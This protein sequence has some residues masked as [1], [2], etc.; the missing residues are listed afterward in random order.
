LSRKSRRL[1]AN[2][3]KCGGARGATND[4]TTW[5]LRMEC[6]VSKAT[7]THTHTDKYVIFIAIPRQQWFANASPCYVI[8]TLSVLLCCGSL[9]SVLEALQGWPA[10][11]DEDKHDTV[12]VHLSDRPAQTLS[13]VRW[14][15]PSPSACRPANNSNCAALY[16]DRS[17]TK[18]A[19]RRLQVA[20]T[21]DNTLLVSVPNALP[22]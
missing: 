8:H 6:W 5:R 16:F 2:V 19:L 9:D 7:C 15:T 10:R 1:W 4:V 21:V 12:V 17:S 20:Q 14:G 11:D 13:D 22:C 3:E 18:E